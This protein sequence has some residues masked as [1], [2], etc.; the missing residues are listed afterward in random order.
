MASTPHGAPPSI[1]SLPMQA[2]RQDTLDVSENCGT[3]GIEV[4]LDSIISNELVAKTNG[5][6]IVKSEAADGESGHCLLDKRSA[7]T[8]CSPESSIQPYV[9][10]TERWRDDTHADTTQTAVFTIP[11]PASQSP[12]MTSPFVGEPE[13]EEANDANMRTGGPQRRNKL[14]LL[15][16]PN[17]VLFHI[18]SYLE[19]CDLLAT[20][21]VRQP[22]FCLL[23]A[24]KHPSPLA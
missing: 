3:T 10:T 6:S 2:S 1:A 19:V 4:D 20:S 17:E 21:R 9:A 15:D 23:Y 7:E 12:K 18:L 5:L 11:S 24:Q 13:K 16:L 14:Q 22:P 8:L